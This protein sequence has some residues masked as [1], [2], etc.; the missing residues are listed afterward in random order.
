MDKPPR[1]TVEVLYFEGCPNHQQTSQLARDVVAELGVDAT[2]EEVEV[3]TLEDAVRLRFLGSPNVHVDGVDIEPAARSSRAYGFACRT[4]GQAAVPPRE[5]LVAALREKRRAPSSGGAGW[6]RT[7]ATLPGAV[8]LLLPVG[9]C[10]AC[11]PAYAGLL[12]PLGMSFLLYDRYLL[13]VAA[14]LLGGALASLAYR[15]RSRRGYRAFWLGLVGSLVGLGGKFVLSSDP[16]LYMGLGLVVV[17]AGWNAWP[18]DVASVS[19]AGC[20]PQE[21]RAWTTRAHAMMRSEHE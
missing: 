10:P 8:A 3:K 9:T 18:L 20:A 7:L 6:R 5:L 16:L 1:K 2:V 21:G 11:W 19:C 13:P 14:A 4:Y 12:S 15:A 17:A